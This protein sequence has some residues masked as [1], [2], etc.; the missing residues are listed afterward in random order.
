MFTIGLSLRAQSRVPLAHVCVWSSRTGWSWRMVHS[1]NRRLAGG[2]TYIG[3][4]RMNA[5]LHNALFPAELSRGLLPAASD[6]GPSRFQRANN[7]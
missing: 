4:P 1:W 2:A 5:A 6:P 7:S 3:P